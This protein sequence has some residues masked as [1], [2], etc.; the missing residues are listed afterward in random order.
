MTRN[1]HL[2]WATMLRA[3]AKRK[4]E[5]FEQW[6]YAAGVRGDG[7]LQLHLLEHATQLRDLLRKW[8][9]WQDITVEEYMVAQSE[10]LDIGLGCCLPR[11]R[12]ARA[13]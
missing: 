4:A 7:R 9:D 3:D 6:A 12:P 11:V 8:R 10:H 1:D 13:R 5:E 2:N